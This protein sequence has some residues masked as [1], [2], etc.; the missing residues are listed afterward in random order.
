M[1]R[2]LDHYKNERK[3]I[4]FDCICGTIC[5]IS[6]FIGIFVFTLQEGIVY[7]VYFALGLLF[8]SIYLSISLFVIGLGIYTYYKAKNYDPNTKPKKDLRAPM[9]S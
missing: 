4:Y 3:Q 1:S 6:A 5:S 8:F 2:T 9:V 7:P